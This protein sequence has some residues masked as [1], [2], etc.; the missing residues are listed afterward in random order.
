MR[1]VFLV[2]L[3]P[4]LFD[5]LGL[6]C[7]TLACPVRLGTFLLLL[8]SSFAHVCVATVIVV[9]LWCIGGLGWLGD[10]SHLV[11]SV[12]FWYLCTRV[13]FLYLLFVRD[14]ASVL[15]INTSSVML[16]IPT[17]NS[18]GRRLGTTTT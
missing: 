7:H 14:D 9:P 4:L 1:D 17:K 2:A 11:A 18:D 6:L 16:P 3:F 8:Y 10:I 15:S 5:S 13:R 12:R